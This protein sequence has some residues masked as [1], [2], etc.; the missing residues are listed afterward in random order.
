MQDE[1][2]KAM[3]GKS[4]VMA[5]KTFCAECMAWERPLASAIRACTD[6]GCPLYPYRPYRESDAANSDAAECHL[7]RTLESTTS[8]KGYIR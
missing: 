1:Y 3:T 4:R 7:R 2:R 5:V 8:E 6:Q